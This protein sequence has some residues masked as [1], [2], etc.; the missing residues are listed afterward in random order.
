MNAIE[1]TAPEDG[2]L[3][4]A[5]GKLAMKNVAP[6]LTRRKCIIRSSHMVNEL[7]VNNPAWARVMAADN[8]SQYVRRSFLD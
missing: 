2:F 6:I 3:L 8:K 7:D 5:E 4:V 1:Q